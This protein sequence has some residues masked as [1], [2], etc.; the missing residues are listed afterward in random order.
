MSFLRSSG[1]VLRAPTL[2]A[3]L[4]GHLVVALAAIGRAAEPARTSADAGTA[5]A[6]PPDNSVRPPLESEELTASARSLFEAVVR[7][8]ATIAEPFF[9]PREPFLVLKDVADPD[10][11]HRE[12]V[13]AF[14]HDVHELHSKRRTWEGAEFVSFELGTPPRWV[15]PGDEWNKIGYFRTLDGR[16]R[17][18]FKGKERELRVR[19]IISWNGRWYVTHLLPL[20]APARKAG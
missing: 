5:P 12:L 6:A 8:D 14:R 16:V 20:R 2:G 7:D 4:F 17:Y 9:F 19:T 15:K 13:R 3:V 18:T 10:K 11:Y 1:R